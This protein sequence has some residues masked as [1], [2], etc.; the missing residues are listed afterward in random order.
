MAR[1]RLAT[2]LTGPLADFDA[3]VPFARAIGPLAA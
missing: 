2:Q 1:N 3:P